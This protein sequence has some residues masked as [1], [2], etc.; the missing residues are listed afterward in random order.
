MISLS[1]GKKEGYQFSRKQNP[2]WGKM[3]VLT[4][5]FLLLPAPPSQLLQLLV[6]LGEVTASR[7]QRH[8]EFQVLLGQAPVGSQGHLPFQ[9]ELLNLWN[10]G[11]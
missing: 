11:W 6:F 9:L 10:S 2:S 3:P 5:L 8:L 7:L 4:Q 1:A